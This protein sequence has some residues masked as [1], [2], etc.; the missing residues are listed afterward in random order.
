MPVFEVLTGSALGSLLGMRHALE[1]DHLTAV[2]TLV[3]SSSGE[4][5]NVRAAMLGASWGIGHTLSL[6]VV[7]AVLVVLRAEMPARVADIFELL[8]AIMLVALGVRAILIAV[9]Q[10]PVG[11]THTHHHGHVVHRHAGARPHVHVVRR[12]DSLWSIARRTGMDVNTLATMNGMQPGDTLRA[13][14]KLRL[15][16]ASASNASRAKLASATAAATADASGARP[17]SYT[18]RAGDTLSAIARMFQVTV[19]QILD[20]NDITAHTLIKPGQKL[21]I[22]VSSRRG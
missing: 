9:R 20:W 11:P 13:G 19:A 3:T 22:R 5:S 16:S 7:G 2:S 4:R 6:V 18:V 8:V 1:P 15:T 12:G 10:G 21:T 17:V 14:Q